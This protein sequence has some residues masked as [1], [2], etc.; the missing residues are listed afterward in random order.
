MY[1]GMRNFDFI[2]PRNGAS[3]LIFAKGPGRIQ[4]FIDTIIIICES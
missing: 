4:D 3:I 1:E 2:M